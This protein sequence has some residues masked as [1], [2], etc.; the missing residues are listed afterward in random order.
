ML[1]ADIYANQ[2]D[3]AF[4]NI[5]IISVLLIVVAVPEGLCLDA[6]FYIPYSSIL[7]VGL[8][9]AVTLD[10]VLTARSIATRCGIF[11]DGGIIMEGPVFR[12]LN[13]QDRTEIVPWLRVL[14]RSSP[15]DKEFLLETPKKIGEIV[16]VAG[17]G[18]N[19]GP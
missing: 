2:N 19:D 18:T 13:Q 5:P 11:T 15:E 16:G 7:T 1:D 14:A 17:D 8:P 6:D 12:R 9:L 4:V 3:I 10:N